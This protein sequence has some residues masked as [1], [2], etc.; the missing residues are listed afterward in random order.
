MRQV[1]AAV[2]V[3]HIIIGDIAVLNIVKV[4]SSFFVAGC[5]F[6]SE[7]GDVH[8]IRGYLEDVVTWIRCVHDA[9]CTA[10]L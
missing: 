6:H 7:S 2:V 8:V 9:I 1:N 3:R 5:P 4:D 10:V